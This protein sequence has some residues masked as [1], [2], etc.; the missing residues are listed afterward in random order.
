MPCVRSGCPHRVSFSR[1]SRA[2]SP[3]ISC[4]FSHFLFIFAQFSLWRFFCFG[5]LLLLDS[6]LFPLHFLVSFLCFLLCFCSFMVDYSL[7]WWDC[8]SV[9]FFFA[10]LCGV[11]GIV[12]RQ[13]PKVGFFVKKSCPYRSVL[14]F[15][16]PLV[17]RSVGI[18]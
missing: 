15:L 12:G 2:Q 9:S 11:L 3:F 18:A 13:R 5:V 6:S 4:F 1:F 8:P 10:R 7:V 14:L 16:F 17:H